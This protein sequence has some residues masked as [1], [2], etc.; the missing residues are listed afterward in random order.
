[1]SSSTHL[2][3]P[4][5]SHQRW[6]RL[7][8]SGQ[9]LRAAWARHDAGDAKRE[10]EALARTLQRD[11]AGAAASLREGLEETLTVTRLGVRDPLL[12]TVFSTNPMES[13][14]EIV[15]EHAS[16]VK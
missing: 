12:K 2:R 5:D 16:T 8:G 11:H 13:M 9:H 1:M 3:G 7:R 6:S 10:L 14:I 4:K 15:R